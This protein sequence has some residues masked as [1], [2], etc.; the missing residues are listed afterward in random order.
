MAA[1]AAV[2]GGDMV[3]RLARSETAVM[4]GSAFPVGRR[5]VLHFGIA[6]DLTV[7]TGIAIFPG[8]NMV[9]R[10]AWSGDSTTAGMAGG[11]LTGSPFEGT[12]DMTPVTADIGVVTLQWETGRKMIKGF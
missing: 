1:V 10:F 7:V 5:S 6:P 2:V 3:R 9:D 11:A 8:R 4:A 12:P